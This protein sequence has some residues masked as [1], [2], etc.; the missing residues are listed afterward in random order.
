MLAQFGRVPLA[1]ERAEL[2]TV[3]EALGHSSRL[4]NLLRYVGEKYLQGESDELSEYNIA[5]EVFGRS[6]ST[7]DASEDA[8]ARVEAHR[9]RKK[10][11]DFYR[12]PGKDHT[13]QISIPPGSYVPVFTRVVS[14]SQNRDARESLVSPDGNAGHQASATESARRAPHDRATQGVRSGLRPESRWLLAGLVLV[15][16]AT[17]GIA[18]A[19]LFRSKFSTPGTVGSRIPTGALP[20]PQKAGVASAQVPIR[21][22]A[23]YSGAPQTDSVGQIWSA[24]EYVHGGGPWRRPDIPIARTSDPFI[25]QYW[26]TGDSSYDIPL[27]PGVYEL[28]LYFVSSKSPNDSAQAFIV[29]INGNLVLQGFDINSDAMGENVADERV[30][31]DISPAGDG[32]LHISLTTL[33][34][35][36]QVNAIE[37]LPGTSHKQLP[38]RLVMQAATFTDHNGQ[39]WHPDD[40][41]MNGHLSDLHHEIDGSTDPELFSTERYGHFSYAIPVD[42]RDRYTLILHFV[43]LYFGSQAGGAD[44]IGSRVFK[45]MCNGETLLDNFD[46][47]KEAGSLHVLTKIFYHLKPSAQGKLNLTFEPIVNNATI[48]GIEVLDESQ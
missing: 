20:A 42:T 9:L 29:R 18:I 30:F 35:A 34:G 6:K 7:F 33:T 19:V 22:L 11:K 26:R 16:V 27:R 2:E 10:L 44:G 4:A 12:G 46:I 43:E 25:F 17:A 1:E 21:L 39:V 5:T 40:Y 45:V 41:Y 15:L 48:S 13:L 47:Y 23:G 28:H 32:R 37:V 3:A 14:A 24:D 38:I 8:I 31:R 36:P